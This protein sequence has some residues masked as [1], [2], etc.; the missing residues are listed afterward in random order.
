MEKKGNAALLEVQ[1]GNTKVRNASLMKKVLQPGP[2]TE[3]T[4]A[5]GGDE[6]GD[7]PTAWKTVGSNCFD[8]ANQY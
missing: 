7:L 5:D 2:C 8:S 4:E 6:A 1:E 3:T